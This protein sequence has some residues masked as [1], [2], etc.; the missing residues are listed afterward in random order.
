VNPE[1]CGGEGE[2]SQKGINSLVISWMGQPADHGTLETRGELDPSI[3]AVCTFHDDIKITKM[4][5]TAV[6]NLT[7]A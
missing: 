5:L 2:Y 3:T 6:G 7:L 4:S 1:I